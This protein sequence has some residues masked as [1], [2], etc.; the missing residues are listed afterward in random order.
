MAFPVAAAVTAAASLLGTGAN[1]IQGGKM[2]KKNREFTAEQNLINR[3]QA[4]DMW[5]A[6]NDFNLMTSDP[7]FQ[8]KRWKDAG[9]NPW[10]I[11][12]NPQKVD[13]SPVNAQQHGPIPQ[14]GADLSGI[15]KSTEQFL[16]AMF[17]KKQMESLDSGIAKTQAE[18]RATDANT[19]LTQQRTAQEAELFPGTVTA[20]GLQNQNLSTQKDKMIQEIAS[21]GKQMD[22]TNQEISNMK[23]NLANS[24]VEMENLRKQGKLLEASTKEKELSMRLFEA[25][26]KSKADAENAYNNMIK[27]TGGIG[28]AGISQMPGIILGATLEAIKREL[29]IDFLGGKRQ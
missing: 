16:Q 1:M 27:N 15:G 21:I 19:T 2:N 10:L 20:Q 11:Y 3:Q 18:T 22:K 25:T 28:K 7:A 24:I 6:T 8:M 14:V 12:G 26:M 4:W 13:A 9:L 29:G 23:Q 5:N 17:M